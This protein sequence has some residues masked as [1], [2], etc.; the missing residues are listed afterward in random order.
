MTEPRFEPRR[1]HIVIPLVLTSALVVALLVVGAIL[2]AATRAADGPTPTGEIGTPLS[3]A[4]GYA[5]WC[6]PT[7]THC[8]KWGGTA[9]V[10]AVR[11]FR[12][13]DKPYTVRVCLVSAPARCTT[14]VV[15]SYCACGPR[16]GEATVIDLSPAA[17]RELRPLSRG[18]ALV[19]VRRGDITLP[20]TSTRGE[21]VWEGRMSD[22]QRIAFWLGVLA[23]Y[24]VIKRSLSRR[25]R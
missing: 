7:P 3:V 22:V 21:V 18:I 11:S 6:A 1:Y 9:H 2:A 14:V 24:V 8:Q 19:T 17:F 20:A 4:K 15:V 5:T 23:A 25:M 13:G 16:K 10:G 12:S